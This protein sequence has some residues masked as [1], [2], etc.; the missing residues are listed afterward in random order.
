M[1]GV[2]EFQQYDA[3]IHMKTIDIFYIIIVI[4]HVP[5]LSAFNLMYTNNQPAMSQ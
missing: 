2:P 5:F 3:Y 1:R 4:S